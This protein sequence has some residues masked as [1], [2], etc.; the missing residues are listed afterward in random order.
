MLKL[1]LM[2]AG[3]FLA[4]GIASAVAGFWGGA[5]VCAIALVAAVVVI[6]RG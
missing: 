3:I 6:D 4:L 5:I 1:N 2:F